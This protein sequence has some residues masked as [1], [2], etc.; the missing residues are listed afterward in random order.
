MKVSV[1]STS[2]RTGFTLIELLVVIAIIAILAAMLLPALGRAKEKAKRVQCLNNLRQV[3][4]GVTLYAG[5]FNDRVPT[6]HHPLSMNIGMADVLKPY[7]MMLKSEPSEVNNIWSCPTR[8][9]LPRRDPTYTT[10]IA[11]GYLYYG[12][13]RSWPNN[14]ANI[15]TT[16]NAPSP[17]KLGSARPNWCMASEANA[18]FTDQTGNNGW[19]FDGQTTGQRPRVPHQRPG[20]TH[21]D[22][23][24]VL[25][26]DSSVRWVRFENMY[27]MTTWNPTRRLFAYQEDWGSW[28]PTAAQLTAMRPN[29][30]DL[31]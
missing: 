22:G 6:N 7:G 3:G 25:F 2:T 11:L 5:D 31:R 1:G 23:G 27:M 15:A 18:R 13:M 17:V 8:N 28:N 30:T 20:R 9:F 10:E 29:T 16:G 19:G 14:P 26:V 21:P 4:V 24:N 12:G